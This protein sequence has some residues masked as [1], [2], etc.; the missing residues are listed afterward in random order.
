MSPFVRQQE[1]D[2]PHL[3]L[4]KYDTQEL[5]LKAQSMNR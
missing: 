2:F 3:I 1:Y 4:G 5:D